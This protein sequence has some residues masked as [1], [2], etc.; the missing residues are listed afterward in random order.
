LKKKEEEEEEEHH[1]ATLQF[2]IEI[3][4]KSK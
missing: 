2:Y 1:H 3:E 4:D